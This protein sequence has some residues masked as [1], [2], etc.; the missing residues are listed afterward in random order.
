MCHMSQYKTI[1]IYEY[2]DLY[3][4]S[5]TSQL[6]KKNIYNAFECHH[7]LILRI[8]SGKT[9]VATKLVANGHT[10]EIFYMLDEV[11]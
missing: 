10:Y 7:V 11:V 3:W 9:S 8:P 1:K 4:V 6:Q 2:D 5:F